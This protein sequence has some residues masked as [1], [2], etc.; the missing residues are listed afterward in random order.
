MQSRVGSSLLPVLVVQSGVERSAE[1]FVKVKQFLTPLCPCL[2]PLT[3]VLTSWSRRRRRRSLQRSVM[4]AKRKLDCL[5]NLQGASCFANDPKRLK[6]LRD[7]LELASSISAINKAQADD[8]Q[9]KTEMV[10]EFVF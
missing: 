7:Q 1:G 5:G 8:R 10:I 6:Q 2:P 9:A 4:F 3:S